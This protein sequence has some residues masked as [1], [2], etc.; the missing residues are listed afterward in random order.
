MLEM[1]GNYAVEV[2]L[3]SYNCHVKVE[4]SSRKDP[5]MSGK[6]DEASVE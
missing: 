2:S 3:P 1:L 6:P 4:F 5:M